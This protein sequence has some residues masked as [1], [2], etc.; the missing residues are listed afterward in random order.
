MFTMRLICFGVIAF[1]V[2]G[3]MS[4][5][6]E[7]IF[8]RAFEPAM[9][10]SFPSKPTKIT[11]LGFLRPVASLIAAIIL[12]MLVIATVPDAFASAPG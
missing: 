12:A 7:I 6:S 3:S 8:H 2:T 10:A 4:F 1:P 9:S 5:P 11:L